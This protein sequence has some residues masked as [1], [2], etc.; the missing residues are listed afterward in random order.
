M[1][2]ALTFRWNSECSVTL[3]VGSEKW[4]VATLRLT[5]LEAKFKLIIRLVLINES[6]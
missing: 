6:P 2:I 1:K 4:G 3:A 5:E